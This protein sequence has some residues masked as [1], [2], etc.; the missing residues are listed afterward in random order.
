MWTHVL[1]AAKATSSGGSSFLI[2]IA[3]FAVMMIFLFR[4]QRQAPASDPWTRS[5]R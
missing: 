5:D 3:V 4:S 2:I 1:A